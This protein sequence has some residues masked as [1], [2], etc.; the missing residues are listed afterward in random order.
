M[1]LPENQSESSLSVLDSRP[2]SLVYV[3]SSFLWEKVMVY[4]LVC[5]IYDYTLSLSLTI[6][7]C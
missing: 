5:T 6:V 1:N 2:F 7:V 4:V 3:Y